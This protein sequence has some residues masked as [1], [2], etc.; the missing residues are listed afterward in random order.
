MD[1]TSRSVLHITNG[2]P[3][4]LT[5]DIGNQTLY[6]SDTTNNIIEKSS[7]D[8]REREVLAHSSPTGITFYDG[9]LY[10]CRSIWRENY[11]QTMPIDSPNHVSNF[12]AYSYYPRYGIQVVSPYL[13]PQGWIGKLSTVYT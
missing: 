2:S 4:A 3:Y 6:W 8:G 12:G 1:G 5:L 11:L 7:T 10:W 13:Q 9:M